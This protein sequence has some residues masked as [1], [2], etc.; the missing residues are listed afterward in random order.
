M[1]MATPRTAIDTEK[2]R[3]S[4]ECVQV[5]PQDAISIKD[6]RA[7]LDHDVCDLAGL[8]IPACPHA[9]ISLEE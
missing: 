6:G 8:C 3:S 9:A 7:I 1:R 4:G 5:C 2:C